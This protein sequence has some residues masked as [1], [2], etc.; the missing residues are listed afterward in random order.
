LFLNSFKDLHTKLNQL[1]NPRDIGLYRDDG[2]A[3]FK[4][5]RGPESERIKKLLQALF[6]KN[7][8]EIVIES[9]KKIVD[10]LTI[11][12]NLNDSTYKPYHKPTTNIQYLY[13]Q[14]DHPPSIIKQIPK[15]IEKRLLSTHQTKRYST[16]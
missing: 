8:L 4:N 15:S 10:Y 14:S 11:T 9:N 2:L 5:V 3:V 12:L 7:G 1:Y 16:Q 6:K 13:T